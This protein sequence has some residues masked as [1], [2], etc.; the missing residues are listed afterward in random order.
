MTPEQIRLMDSIPSLFLDFV[1]ERP[2]ANFVFVPEGKHPT[3]QWAGV[4]RL[5]AL[6]QVAGLARRLQKIGVKEGSK[7]AIWANTRAEWCWIDVAVLSLGAVTVGL[8]PTLT[9]DV[10][11]EQMRNAEVEIL[12]VET[13]QQHIQWEESFDALRHLEYVFTIDPGRE[14][15]QIQSADVDLVWYR[16][17]VASLTS[18][19]LATIVFTSGSTGH[20]KGVMLS[21]QNFLWNLADTKAVLPLKGSVRSIVCLPLAH[22]LQRFVVYR[23]FVEDIEGYF[24]PSLNAIKETLVETKPTLLIV[25]PRMLEK[26]QNMVYQQAG[27]R[28]SMAEKMVRWAMEVG[29]KVREHQAH[30]RRLPLRLRAQYTVLDR[31]VLSKIRARLGNSLQTIISGGAAL[32]DHTAKFFMALGMDVVEGWGLSESCAP[33]TLNTQGVLKLGSVGQAMPSVDLRISD[34]SEV[35]LKGVG[36]FSGYYGMDSSAAF[37]SDGFFKTGDLGMLDADGFLYITGR[38]KDII[39][40]AGGKNIA[41]RRI[42]SKIEGDLIHHCIAIGDEQPY[43]VGLIALDEAYLEN[44]AQNNG[45]SGDFAQWSTQQV[46]QQMIQ[47]RVDIANTQLASFEQLKRVAILSVPLTESDGLLTSTQKIKRAVI[48]ERFENTW[49]KLYL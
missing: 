17:Q 18:D 45:W 29:W 32:N 12:I 16:Q 25:V 15:L 40:T 38:S 35:L 10:L 8:Y 5:E 31:V 1:D 43:L 44:L 11:L 9:K 4:S 20:S 14:L 36:I 39:V 28:S 26:I 24:A 21:H 34:H 41:P 2:E 30:E 42:E 47:D 13:E 46:V 23:A 7:V 33:A 3:Y 19:L 22:S 49:K 48:L 6:E 27:Q 37:D